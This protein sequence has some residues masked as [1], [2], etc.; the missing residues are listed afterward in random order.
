MNYFGTKQ[1][2]KVHHFPLGGNIRIQAVSPLVTIIRDGK[3]HCGE[4]E[5]G[6]RYPSQFI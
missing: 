6:L 4:T 2:V 1:L 3:Q 5:Q